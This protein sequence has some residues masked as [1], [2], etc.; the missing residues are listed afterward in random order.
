M[1]APSRGRRLD[2]GRLGWL[3]L[4]IALGLAPGSWAGSADDPLAGISH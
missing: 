3:L 4:P 2:P 1:G